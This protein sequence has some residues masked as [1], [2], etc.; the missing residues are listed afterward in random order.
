M[1]NLHTVLPV[2]VLW[3]DFTGLTTL[4]GT[5][6]FQCLIIQQV[7]LSPRGFEPFERRL[8]RVEA[9]AIM[10]VAL[11]SVLELLLRALAMGGG[12]LSNVAGALP[13]MLLE[14]RY[15]TIWLVRIALIGLVALGWQFWP[16][17]TW[18]TGIRLLGA[19]AIALTRSLSGH[20]A[21]WGDVTFAVLMDWL[22][23]L[24]VS[25]WIG[26]LLMIGFVLRAALI[27]TSNQDT[28]L[29]FTLI[30]RRFSFLATVC[31]V[32]LLATGFFHPRL[33]L[34]SFSTLFRIPYGWTLLV[35]LSLVLLML[36][37]GAFN[38][39]YL[40]PRLGRGRDGRVRFYI[41]TIGRLEWILAVFVL[42]SS[43][44]LTQ[45]TPARHVRPTDHRQ[46]HAVLL[47]ANLQTGR[48]RLPTFPIRPEA[49]SEK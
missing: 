24:A 6:A 49:E 39:Y 25:V 11:T 37:L 22:H 43:A 5:L 19:V 9:G 46:P 23:L 3:L 20:A 35:K 10:L 1:N 42:V 12:I 26:G 34:M 18:S 15:G 48:T 41:T 36:L 17:I 14:T 28:A 21:D 8:L 44:L 29:G 47:P 27:P 30:A 38:R 13:S 33:R 4:I 32:G 31:V 16:R 2:F 7:S 45:L 40:L